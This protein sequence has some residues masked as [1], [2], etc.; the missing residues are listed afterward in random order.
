MTPDELR[1]L[2]ARHHLTEAALSRLLGVPQQTVNRWVRGE[3]RPRLGALVDQ[4]LRDLDRRLSA[5]ERRR[6]AAGPGAAPEE[7]P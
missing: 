4:R 2:L 3:R 5:R 1:A 7:G 6:Q